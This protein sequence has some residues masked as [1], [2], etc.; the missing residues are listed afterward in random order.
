MKDGIQKLGEYADFNCYYDGCINHFSTPR[1]AYAALID[2]INGK[3][4]WERNPFVFVYD[5]NFLKTIKND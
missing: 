1:K 2:H 4:T 3:G 5:F